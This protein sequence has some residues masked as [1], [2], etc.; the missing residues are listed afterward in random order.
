[1]GKIPRW[2]Q[3]TRSDRPARR[4]IRNRRPAISAVP[5]ISRGCDANST[6]TSVTPFWWR[7]AIS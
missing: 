2:F 5:R 4:R 7:A 1:V 6:A 3:N